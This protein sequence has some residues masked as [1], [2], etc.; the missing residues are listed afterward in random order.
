MIFSDH[1]RFKRVNDNYGRAAGDKV[2]QAV[3]QRL[4][5]ARLC[6][7][8]TLCRYGGEAML[9]ENIR[10][11]SSGAVWRYF[12]LTGTTGTGG[13]FARGFGRCFLRHRLSRWLGSRLCC[14]RRIG[15]R[16]IGFIGLR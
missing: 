12:R 8:D 7:E 10:R 13:R 11:G 14:R 1:D 15:H 6:N 9:P 2:P 3:A 16:R 4:H 5:G